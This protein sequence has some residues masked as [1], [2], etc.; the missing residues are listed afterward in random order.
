MTVLSDMSTGTLALAKNKG[1]RLV[2]S[3]WMNRSREQMETSFSSSKTSNLGSV[4]AEE[5]KTND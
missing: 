3:H 2:C 1:T 5:K 4:M